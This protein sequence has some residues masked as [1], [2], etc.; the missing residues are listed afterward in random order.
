MDADFPSINP[1]D[2]ITIVTHFRERQTNHSSIGAYSASINFL[3][4]HVAEFYRF[5]I[6]FSHLFGTENV[7]TKI[8]YELS[9]AQIL[10]E[11]PIE[12]P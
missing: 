8:T 7:L 10:A 1:N 5:E 12:E 11:G 9:E 6:A 2:I 3:K 4:D